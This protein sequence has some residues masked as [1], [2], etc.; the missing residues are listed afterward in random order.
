MGWC[1]QRPDRNRR[2]RSRMLLKSERELLRDH[3]AARRHLRQQ[4]GTL[5]AIIGG[6][7][8][9]DIFLASRLPALVAF[10]GWHEV[11]IQALILFGPMALLLLVF[12]ILRHRLQNPHLAEL[13][14][15]DND[16]AAIFYSEQSSPVVTSTDNAPP[17]TPHHPHIIKVRPSASQAGG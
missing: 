5:A 4:I 3:R 12:W 1:R 10:T 13:S 7:L 8:L 14:V 17:H 16:P 9:L 11:T 15:I 2:C 6:Y